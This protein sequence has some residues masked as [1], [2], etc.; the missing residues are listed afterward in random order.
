MDF[1][2]SDIASKQL[3]TAYQR[4]LLDSMNGDL[5]L[6]SRGDAI[7][8]TWEYI[9]PILELWKAEPTLNLYPYPV[10]SW[11]PPAY[12]DL[13]QSHTGFEWRK[14]FE[15]LSKS[16]DLVSIQNQFE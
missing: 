6:Y 12:R 1:H 3:P 10:N 11:G 9:Q 2:Y 15:N 4:L 13:I 14:P 16:E 7:E 8:Y 5:T